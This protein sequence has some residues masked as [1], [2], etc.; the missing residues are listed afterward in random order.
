MES[1]NGLTVILLYVSRQNFDDDGVDVDVGPPLPPG[2]VK[3]SSSREGDVTDD[4][5]DHEKEDPKEVGMHRIH[6]YYS[7]T[8][9]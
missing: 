3:P 4:E 1:T 6:T 9:T 8:E 5:S 2:F 7:S